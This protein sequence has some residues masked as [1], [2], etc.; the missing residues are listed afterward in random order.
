MIPMMSEQTVKGYLQNRRD[1]LKRQ[2][3]EFRSSLKQDVEY[4]E[5]KLDR[6][7]VEMYPEVQKLLNQYLKLIDFMGGF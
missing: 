3:D 2:I 7:P 6:I 5:D 4:I 1:T